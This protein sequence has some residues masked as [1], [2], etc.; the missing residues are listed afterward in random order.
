MKNKNQWLER[1]ILLYGAGT[2]AKFAESHVLIVGLGGV[3]GAAAEFLGRAGI[4]KFTIADS[5]T[6]DVTNRNRQLPALLSTL[7][8]LKTDVVAERLRDINPN[9]EI[10]AIPEFV[11]DK[12]TDEIL[13]VGYDFVIDAIDTLTFKVN[14][15]AKTLNCGIPLISS[16]GSGGKTDISQVKVA[17]IED[18]FQCPLARMVRKKLHKMGIYKGFKVVFSPEE[19]PGHAVTECTEKKRSIVG[20]VSYMPAVFGA[21]C[22]A[23]ALKTIGK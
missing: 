2:V 1:T 4:G 18:T 7:G 23:E 13:S 21:Y 3:G 14:L 15:I 9:V 5:D 10:V 17:E 6:V 20:T 22:A 16:M 12:K 19:C 11:R 8:R